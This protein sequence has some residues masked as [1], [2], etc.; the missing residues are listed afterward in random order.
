M[1][2]SLSAVLLLSDTHGHANFAYNVSLKHNVLSL[3]AQILVIVASR[4]TTGS[5]PR[6]ASAHG[7]LMQLS[8]SFRECVQGLHGIFVGVS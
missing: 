4:S 6:A 2:L 7:G 8:R 1:A 5:G 3:Q